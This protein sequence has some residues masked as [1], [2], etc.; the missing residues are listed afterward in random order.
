MKTPQG[1]INPA[2]SQVHGPTSE[3]L[4]G[5]KVLCKDGKEV[6]IVS[7]QECLSQLLSFIEKAREHYKKSTTKL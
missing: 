7:L 1:A 6:H 5:V 2:A 4:R 3:L